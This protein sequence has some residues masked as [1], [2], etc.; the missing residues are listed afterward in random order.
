MQRIADSPNQGRSAVTSPITLDVCRDPVLAA[1]ERD[2][3]VQWIEKQGMDN[4][5]QQSVCVNDLQPIEYTEQSYETYPVI[6]S[7]EKDTTPFSSSPNFEPYG[8]D[9]IQRAVFKQDC[10]A[11]RV[12]LIVL[13]AMLIL[14]PLV[15]IPSVILIRYRFGS[16]ATSKRSTV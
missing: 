12:L 10:S 8:D 6:Y 5:T 1:D 16:T 9:V 11:K 14:A 7:L 15:A 4:F 3:V 13:V 2:V